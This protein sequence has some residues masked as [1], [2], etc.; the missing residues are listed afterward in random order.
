MNQIRKT[1]E[2]FLPRLARLA[3]EPCIEAWQAAWLQRWPTSGRFNEY[4]PD[5][6]EVG[7]A[8]DAQTWILLLSSEPDSEAALGMDERIQA[9]GL[10]SLLIVPRSDG[11]WV[12]A[13]RHAELAPCLSCLSAQPELLP[14]N[15]R[16]PGLTD[17]PAL[18][19][20]RIEAL[21]H[22]ADLQSLNDWCCGRWDGERIVETAQLLKDPIC[23]V[24]SPIKERP[25][26]V[27]FHEESSHV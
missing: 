24:C 26:Q 13:R 15:R 2:E 22:S 5:S 19:M 21:L 23:A 3:C 25:N 20:S 12:Q 6:P 9:S 16:A 7:A 27:Y 11:L 10:R 18:L 8:A 4:S 14:W 1:S 17:S